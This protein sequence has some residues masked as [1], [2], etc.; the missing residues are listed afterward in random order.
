[1]GEVAITAIVVDA[2]NNSRINNLTG[3]NFSGLQGN[4]SGVR[5]IGNGEYLLI[6]DDSLTGQN[7]GSSSCTGT[8]E[9]AATA[10]SLRLEVP[11]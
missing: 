8:R 6:F 10:E 9:G 7:R 3:L 2:T 11:R 4:P 1:M 5:P